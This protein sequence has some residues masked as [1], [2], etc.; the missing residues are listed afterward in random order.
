MRLSPRVKMPKKQADRSVVVRDICVA[1]FDMAGD[2]TYITVL[3]LQNDSFRY[4]N[5]FVALAPIIVIVSILGSI[6]SLW[7]IATSL[8]RLYTYKSLCCR[9]TMPRLTMGLILPHHMPIFVM[10]LYCDLTFRGDISSTG[11]FNIGSSMVALI[12]TLSVTNCA[13][14][15]CNYT[16][17]DDLD[18]ELGSLAD[19]IGSEYE[20]MPP[21][22]DNKA[23][24]Q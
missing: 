17:D 4:H 13:E 24:S 2:W 6:I 5:Q 8:G 7:S 20:S 11:Y 12:N 9:C 19:S 3:F 18:V 21:G 10:T 23:T 1:L 16:V 14:G 22:N 15:F